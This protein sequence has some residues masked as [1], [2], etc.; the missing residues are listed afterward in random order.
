MISSEALFHS[1]SGDYNN[2]PPHEELVILFIMFQHNMLYNI[3][4]HHTGYYVSDDD[5]TVYKF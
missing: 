4:C 2:Y 1:N 5:V 3:T